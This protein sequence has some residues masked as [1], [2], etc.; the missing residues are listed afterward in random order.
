MS[1]FEILGMA[2]EC[3]FTEFGT[4]SRPKCV[5]SKKTSFQLISTKA[6]MVISCVHP[7]SEIA[8]VQAVGCGV[9]P[10]MEGRRRES[11][12]REGRKFACAG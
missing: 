10:A 3:A 11:E 6:F 5:S 7:G 9:V 4:C 1:E 12:G 8:A 2:N